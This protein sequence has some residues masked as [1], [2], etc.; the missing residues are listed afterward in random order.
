MQCPYC[1]E[2]FQDFQEGDLVDIPSEELQL[3]KIIEIGLDTDEDGADF[4]WYNIEGLTHKSFT[5]DELRKPSEQRIHHH[6]IKQSIK[7]LKTIQEQM[8]KLL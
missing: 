2:T 3:V 7:D 6:L 1:G 8:G 4:V 5:A